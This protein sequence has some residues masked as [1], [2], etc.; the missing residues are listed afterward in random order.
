VNIQTWNLTPTLESNLL[1][2]GKLYNRDNIKIDFFMRE[3]LIGS[4][5]DIGAFENQKKEII[6]LVG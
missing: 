2:L 1:N 3:R 6:E 4:N 5:M